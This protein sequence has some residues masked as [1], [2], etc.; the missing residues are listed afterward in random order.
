MSITVER[1][2]PTPPQ[3]LN[4]LA[5]LWIAMFVGLKRGPFGH[6]R[7]LAALLPPE[8]PEFNY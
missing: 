1:T 2:L 8:W 3:M 5:V 7:L 6:I 4:V